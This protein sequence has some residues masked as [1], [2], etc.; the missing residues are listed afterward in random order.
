MQK[1]NNA[2]NYLDS[3]YKFGYY[4]VGDEIITNKIHALKRATETGIHPSWHY[5]DEVYSKIKW[6]ED[7][8]LDLSTLYQ[9][10]AKQIR[11]KYDYIVVSF[12]GG[13]DSWTILKSFHDSETHVDEIFVRWPIQATRGKFKTDVADRHPGNILSEWDLTIIPCLKEIE[14]WFPKTRI[15]IKDW[16]D[17][18]FQ[19]EITD[20]VWL[21]QM[22]TDYLNPGAIPKWNEIS[23]HERHLLDLGRP[24]VLIDGIDKPQLLYNKEDG[25]IYCYFLDKLANSHYPEINSRNTEHF[26]WTP[27]MPEITLVQARMIFRSLEKNS[28]YLSMIDRSRPYDAAVKNIWNNFTR[29]II[30]PDYVKRQFFQANKSY[31]NV[32]DEVDLWMF[33]DGYR[34]TRFMQSWRNVL[35]NIFSSIDQKYFDKKG[36]EIVGYCGFIDKLYCLGSII[37]EQ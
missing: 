13:S 20:D 29:S 28:Q 26:Y 33:T 36:D 17:V 19:T 37:S 9:M 3:K 7:I 35:D 27:E 25:K 8:N 18:V 1:T 11:N 2:M 34:D 6:D 4:L 24:T 23:D 30:Y 12:S 31:T 16:S 14:T 5:H 22:P 15:T 10:R 21:N 32:Y